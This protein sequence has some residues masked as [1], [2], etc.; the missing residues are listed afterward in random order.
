MRI[1]KAYFYCL[2]DLSDIVLNL[3]TSSQKD[4]LNQYVVHLLQCDTE[5]V[6]DTDTSYS[7]MTDS[8]LYNYSM[9]FT[10]SLYAH[11]CNKLPSAPDVTECIQENAKASF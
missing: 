1:G 3:A 10:R 6:A 8:K 5:V 4:P 11:L 9:Q 2:I 7:H